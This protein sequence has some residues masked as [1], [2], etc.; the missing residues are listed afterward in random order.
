[1]RNWRDEKSKKRKAPTMADDT[2]AALEARV[3]L[4]EGKLASVLVFMGSKF[5][6]WQEEVSFFSFWSSV[7]LSATRH[8]WETADPCRHIAVALSATRRCSS[9]SLGERRRLQRSRRRSEPG[10][11]AL[12]THTE[13]NSQQ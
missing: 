6:A 5:P 11:V 7:A 4:L 3:A 12:A 13:W 8:L 10:G 9:V 1:M 2:I